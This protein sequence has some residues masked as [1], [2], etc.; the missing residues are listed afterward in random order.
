MAVE[1]HGPLVSR[2]LRWRISPEERRAVLDAVALRQ[3]KASL[4]RFAVLQI[5]AVTIA[6]MGLVTDSAAV[7]IGAMLV[8]PLMSPIMGVAASLSM[9]WIARAARTML[10]VLVA[11]AGSVALAYLLTS[12]VPGSGLTAEVLARTSPGATDMVVALAAG[13]AGAYA[14]VRPNVSAS[15]AGVAVAVALVPPLAAVGVALQAGEMGLAQGA[16]LLFFT[17][18]SAIVL[19]GLVVFPLTGF[20]PATRLRLGMLAYVAVAALVVGGLAL[21]LAGRTLDAAQRAED[22][23][24]AR[25]LT[26]SWL[27]GTGLELTSLDVKGDHVVVVVTGPQVPPDPSSLARQLSGVLGAATEVEVQWL[28][29]STLEARNGLSSLTPDKVAPVVQS[30]LADGGLDPSLFDTEV[31]VDE[32][33]VHLHITGPSNPPDLADLEALLASRF[34]FTVPAEI[35]VTVV[36]PPAAPIADGSTVAAVARTW[37]AERGLT[38][39]ALDEIGTDQYLVVV[40]GPTAPTEMGSLADAVTTELGHDVT[41]EVRF[42]TV[43]TVPVNATTGFRWPLDCDAASPG[44][45]AADVSGMSGSTEW[46]DGALAVSGMDFVPDG[47]SYVRD[48][49]DG[50]LFVWVGTPIAND[51][52][53]ITTT[54][55]SAATGPLGGEIRVDNIGGVAVHAAFV[56]HALDSRATTRC[57]PTSAELD[58]WFG[59]M[60]MAAAADLAAGEGPVGTFIPGRPNDGTTPVLPAG[61]ALVIALRGSGLPVGVEADGAAVL[62]V[63]GV[64]VPLEVTYALAPPGDGSVRAGG[65]TLRLAGGAPA[66]AYVLL[67]DVAAWLADHP[68]VGQSA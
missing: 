36:V 67:D 64:D 12:F 13:L 10:L 19:A 29:R 3:T 40:E 1:E 14:T 65:V 59:R 7:V 15:L 68:L 4:W 46:L 54:P 26:D 51:G 22:V 30:W 34:G 28:Q 11:A 16:L 66:D 9:G 35:E 42:R 2:F 53:Q 45:R 27:T 58:D 39:A 48:H 38:V 62:R 6:V 8:A 60:A 24:K 32:L 37:A 33:S 56:P 31:T 50:T 17:N 23:A 52:V 61:D 63:N 41:I 55:P 43:T 21:L 57:A 25:R 47:S 49:V 44:P 18:L 5:L 20:V